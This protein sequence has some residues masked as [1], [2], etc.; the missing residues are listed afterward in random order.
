MPAR[1]FPIFTGRTDYSRTYIVNPLLTKLVQS[2]W[3]NIGFSFSLTSTS[4]RSI[5]TQERTWPISSY[6]DITLVNTETYRPD[7]GRKKMTE[8]WQG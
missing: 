7:E 2:R 3:L 4:S 6:L 1:V 5:K 8:Q